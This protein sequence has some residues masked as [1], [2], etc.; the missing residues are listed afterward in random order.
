MIVAE[1]S[2]LLWLMTMGKFLFITITTLYALF[3]SGCTRVVTLPV[4]T[5]VDWTEEKEISSESVHD[6]SI[7]SSK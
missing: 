4:R 7:G 5:V 3:F 6:L 2:D 1:R